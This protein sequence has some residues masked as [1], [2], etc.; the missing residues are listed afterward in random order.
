MHTAAWQF[1]LLSIG[2][3]RLFLFTPQ[4]SSQQPHR[5][6]HTQLG[7]V[8]YIQNAPWILI[9]WTLLWIRQSSNCQISDQRTSTAFCSSYSRDGG[10]PG[11]G[12]QQGQQTH[13]CG[14]RSTG[15][16]NTPLWW[17]K[18]GELKKLQVKIS[19]L[20]NNLLEENN[21]L[22]IQ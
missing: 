15:A 22:K 1:W 17:K 8:L 5:S 19:L 3:G 10:S 12:D 11:T 14:E 18:R 20:K 9:K 2:S 16:A 4:G 21:Y 7:G 13:H 6:A